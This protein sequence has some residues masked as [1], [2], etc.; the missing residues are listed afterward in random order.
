M[1]LQQL[2]ELIAQAR[3][4]LPQDVT[5]QVPPNLLAVY[6]QGC[7][8]TPINAAATG[9]DSTTGAPHTMTNA[10][11]QTNRSS[12]GIPAFSSSLLMACID[13]GARDIGGI[14]PRDEVN[15]SYVFPPI[16]SVT[17]ML[18]HA[19]WAL[20]P[21]LPLYPRHYEWL[22]QRGLKGFMLQETLATW[23]GVH[24]L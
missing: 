14:G 23:T 24:T 12:T 1:P 5:L 17:S 16:S 18:A 2:P 9:S 6:S 19:G 15:A 7:V 4:I 13:A 21:R 10:Q 8:D 22:Q 11:Q 20:R 3:A